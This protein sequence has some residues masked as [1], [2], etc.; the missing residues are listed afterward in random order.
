MLEVMDSLIFIWLFCLVIGVLVGSQKGQLVSGIIWPFLFGP[1]GVIVVVCLSN[2]KKEAEDQAQ[3]AFQFQQIQIQRQQLEEIRKLHSVASEA[4]TL[5]NKLRI[6]KDGQEI[7]EMG[8]GVIKTML[9][10]KQLS[11]NDLYFDPQA[12]EWTPLDFLP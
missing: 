2:K 3:K 1:L 4:P 7:G 9:H 5:P 10:N 12:N 8:I 11:V 6:A